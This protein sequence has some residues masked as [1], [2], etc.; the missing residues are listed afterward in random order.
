MPTRALGVGVATILEPTSG[1]S[2]S[3]FIICDFDAFNFQLIEVQRK[4]DIFSEQDS[5]MPV[6]IVLK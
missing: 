2:S 3:Y 6:S 5:I 4:E 1:C